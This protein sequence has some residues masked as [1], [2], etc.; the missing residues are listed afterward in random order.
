MNIGFIGLGKMG[1]AMAGRLIA[2][3]HALSVYDVNAAALERTVALGAQACG[4]P[5]EVADRAA[6]VFASL[7]AP[8]I[9]IDV[10]LGKDGIVHG[11]ERAIYL[12]TS[13][14][15]PHIVQTIDAGLRKAG[16]AMIDAP[17]SGGKTGAQKGTLAVMAAGP[18]P[19]MATMRP[20]LEIIGQRI[21]EISEQPGTAQI[22]KL[23]NNLLSAATK[24]VS[25]EAMVFGVK[26]GLDPQVMLD[27]INASSGRNTATEYKIPRAVLTRTFDNG[28]RIGNMSKDLHLALA[29]AQRLGVPMWVSHSVAQLYDF[30]VTQGA[31]DH[32]STTLIKYMEAWAGVEVRGKPPS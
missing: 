12:E 2:A 7:P 30:A 20:L 9:S 16:V 32:D 26:A 4:S 25:F 14:L 24:A 13:T 23:A 21:F 17:V 11:R 18:R 27:V 8:E 1:G 22:M 6:I 10:A 31:I 5:R 28:G 29:E 3:G 19:A 15:G